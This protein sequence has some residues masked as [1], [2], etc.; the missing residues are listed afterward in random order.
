MLSFQATVYADSN[1]KYNS[2]FKISKTKKKKKRKKKNKQKKKLG[3][4]S[5]LKYSVTYLQVFG[6]WY[7][8]FVVYL[9]IAFK[10]SRLVTDSVRQ[11]VNA[12][13][14]IRRFA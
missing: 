10:M 7:Q 5:V 1:D 4:L 12:F 14:H 9:Y 11:E 2:I 3:L 13:P 8:G 6:V